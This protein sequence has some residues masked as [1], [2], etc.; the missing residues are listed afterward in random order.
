MKMGTD[1]VKRVYLGSDKVYEYDLA[2]SAELVGCSAEI[3]D[4][5]YYGEALSFTLVPDSGHQQLP[6]NTKVTMGGRNITAEVYD[7]ATGTISISSVTGD[8]TIEAEAVMMPSE[9]EPVEYI[10]NLGS[11][12]ANANYR[13]DMGVRGT[14]KTSI[15]LDFLMSSNGCV[16]HRMNTSAPSNSNTPWIYLQR[17]SN[18][19]FVSGWGSEGDTGPAGVIPLD[20]KHHLAMEKGTFSLN[21]NVYRESET[22]GVTFTT[23]TNLCVLWNIIGNFYRC[24]IK[25]DDV[26][27]CDHIPCRRLSDGYVGLLDQHD[28]SVVFKSPSYFI[29]PHVLTTRH[30]TGCTASRLS[31]AITGT[32][33]RAVIGSTWSIKITPSSGYTFV[34]GTTPQVMIDGVDVTS[35]VVSDNGDGTYNVAIANVEDKPI[36]ITALAVSDGTANATNSVTPLSNNTENNEEE[37]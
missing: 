24:K 11:T 20:V 33:E 7:K 35:Q 3:P 18:Q 9:Y 31:A 23:A 36:E 22:E 10:R 27:V 30:Y 17:N 21:G 29:A 25:E 34:G 32:A 8:I 19:R 1:T 26:E 13:L 37:M 4:S 16:L 6:W 12:T 28:G 5:V 15:Y 14:E 2:V